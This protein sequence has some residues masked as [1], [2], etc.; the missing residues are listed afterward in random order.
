V[1]PVRVKREALLDSSKEVGL[2]VNQEKAKYVLMS[3]RQK[4]G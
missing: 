2:E 4:I 3:R 1:C